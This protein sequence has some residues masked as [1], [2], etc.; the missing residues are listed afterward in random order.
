FNEL[1]AQQRQLVLD[2]RDEVRTGARGPQE[3]RDLLEDDRVAEIEEKTS[4]DILDEAIRDLLLFAIDERWVEH[5]ACLNDLREGI[6][7]RTLA[8][9]KP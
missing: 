4:A 7:L 1:M 5:L 6:H 3:V 9:E 8:R 2:R